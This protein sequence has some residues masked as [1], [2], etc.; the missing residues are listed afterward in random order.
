LGEIFS[1]TRELA[2]SDVRDMPD[3]L[4]AQFISFLEEVN[5]EY[6]LID[7]EGLVNFVA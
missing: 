3:E 2:M 1:A 5:G 6:V 7:R 4:F